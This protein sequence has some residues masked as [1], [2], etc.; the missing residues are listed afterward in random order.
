MAYSVSIMT[1]QKSSETIEERRQKPRRCCGLSLKDGLN[2]LSSLI[3][4]SM[5]GVFTVIIT[6]QQQKI[7]Q[8]QRTEDLQVTRQQ[9][10][11]DRN[12]LRLQRELEWNI[13]L[14]AQAAQ[15]RAV[16]DQYRD[17]LL[18]AYIKE[19]GDMLESKNGAITSDFVSRTLARVKTL[20]ALRQLDGARQIHIIGF[21]FEAGLLTNT[22][23]SNAL[24]LSTAKLI[25]VD[26][27]GLTPR[28]TIEKISLAGVYLEN[29]TFEGKE[30]ENVN[31]SSARL[32]NVNFS[33]IQL[34]KV[35]FSFAVLNNVSFVYSELQDV[36]FYSALLDNV[37]FSPSNLHTLNFSFVKLKHV[38]FS[39][40]SIYTTNFGNASID[41][42]E[43]FS[44]TF[45]TIDFFSAE[46]DNVNFSSANLQNVQFIS[47]G[48]ANNIDFTS[49]DLCKID[50]IR[51]STI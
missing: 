35:D 24:D 9:R 16:I 18:I 27:R 46:L 25:D 3:L 21:L 13:S 19:M 48:F 37:Q 44:V 43:F 30:L 34:S 8:Q 23:E 4:P 39:S 7:A 49:A 31:F 40:A 17:Q 38:D 11:E 32:S 1:D 29:C 36:N 20:N 14:E 26:F 41:D 50:S 47:A 33:L 51:F 12:E 45:E 10:L 22:D 42:S 2:F 15:S 5:L 6:F 28:G